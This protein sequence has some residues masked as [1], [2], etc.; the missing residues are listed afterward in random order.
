[1]RNKGAYPTFWSQI[2]YEVVFSL[3]LCNRDQLP[4][5]CVVIY[6]VNLIFGRR[7]IVH[8][9]DPSNFEGKS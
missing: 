2:L 4:K 8:C 6:K 3:C 5:R 7:I 1:M 9:L